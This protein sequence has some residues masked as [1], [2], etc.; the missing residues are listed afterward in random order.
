MWVSRI[1]RQWDRF[2]WD[3]LWDCDK[4]C[5]NLARILRLPWSVNQKNWAKVEVLASREKESRLFN[6]IKSFANKEQETLEL[7]KKQRQKELEKQI[8]DFW[9]K[10][11]EFYEELNL[12]PAYQIAQLLLP[13]FPLDKNEKNFKNEKHSFTGYFYNRETNTIC[14]WGSRYFNWGT[15]ESCYNNFTLVRNYKNWNDKETFLFFKKL[16]WKK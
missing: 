13:Q 9:E 6:L 2:M 3:K 16:L 1:Y 10:W 12:L 8:K 5:K 4:A 11:N 14:N 15:T 7:Q